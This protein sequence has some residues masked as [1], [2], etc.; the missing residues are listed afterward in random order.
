M[1]KPTIFAKCCVRASVLIG[2]AA[3]KFSLFNFVFT[4]VVNHQRIALGTSGKDCAKR[5][6]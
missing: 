6:N 4:D 1:Q 2:P 5:T 3:T